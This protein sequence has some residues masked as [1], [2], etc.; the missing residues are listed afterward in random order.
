VT[1]LLRLEGISL[2]FGRVTALDDVGLAVAAGEICALI[3]PNGAGKSSLLNVINGVYR[4]DAGQISFDQ[5]RRAHMTP[6]RA[7]RLGI[8]RTFQNIGLFRGMSVLDN[9][10][11]G[12][13]LEI[14]S[15]FL[16]HAL[17]YGPAAREEAGHRGKAEEILELLQ[18]QAHRHT[19]VGKLPYGLQKRVEL[20][21]ALASEPRLLLLDEPMAGMTAEEKRDM[22]R[23][24]LDVNS[25]YGVAV[26]LIEHDLG[27]V[28]ELASHIVVLDYGRKIAD[29]SPEAV[30]HDQSVIDAYLGVPRAA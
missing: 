15:S 22:S 3:G 11:T 14:R 19:P 17:R 16:G 29:G 30:R 28:M 2:S 1:A 21:R 9:I 23:F 5:I 27:V 7:V 6:G 13:T 10:L 8:A 26:V 25:E 18:I 4:P 24:V 12:R 20:G